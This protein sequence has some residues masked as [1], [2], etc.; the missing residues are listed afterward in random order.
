[1]R[2]YGNSDSILQGFD[3]AQVNIETYGNSNLAVEQSRFESVELMADDNSTLS[4]T[5]SEIFNADVAIKGQSDV[6]LRFGHGEN[7]NLTGIVAGMSDLSYCG[8]AAKS[9]KVIELAD[10]N[11]FN[12]DP[13]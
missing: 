12:C 13:Q 4:T 5:K 8:S 9:L 11:K 2:V 6:K 7:G 10:A 3:Q 1:M